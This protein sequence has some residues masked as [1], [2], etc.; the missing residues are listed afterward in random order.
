MSIWRFGAFEVDADAGELRKHGNRLRLR[1]QPLRLLLA[2]VA[3]AGDV[4]TRDQLRHDLWPDGTFVDFDRAINKAVSELRG[5]L[6]DA[7]RSP[8]FVETCSKRGYRFLGSVERATSPSLPGHPHSSI[9]D[10]HQAYLTGRYLWNRRSV[11]DLYASLRY[12]DRA[13]EIDERCTLAHAGLADAHLLIG[14]WGLQPPDRAFGAA[15]QAAAEALARNPD[16]AEAHTS[17]AE[18]LTGYEWDWR[19]AES[20]YRHALSLRPD[21]AT[22]HQF[23]AQMLVCLGRTAEAVSHIET[24]RRSDPISPAINAFL[25]YIYLAARQYGRALQEA[26]RAVDLEPHAPLAHWILG[27]TSLFAGDVE[28]AVTVLDRAV[29]LAGPASMW[30]AQLAYARARAGDRSGAIRLLADLLERQRREHVSPYDLATA[31]AGLEDTVS[32][33]DHLEHAYDQHEMRVINLR[34]PEFGGLCKEPR[35]HRLLERL[36]LPAAP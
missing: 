17:I 20:R 28:R 25:P 3:T 18:V 31:F 23:Y 1:D 24:A 16:L 2:L 6:G 15:R 30:T 4:V 10:A 21:Y 34:D 35:Y 27:R 36:G 7:A 33:L 9:A 13:L 26:E 5:A 29:A 22:A 32:A 19:R 14:I 8:R 12:F 11:T